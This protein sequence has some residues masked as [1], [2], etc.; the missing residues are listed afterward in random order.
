MLYRI[1]KPGLSATV[2]VRPQINRIAVVS[3]DIL[4]IEREADRGIRISNPAGIVSSACTSIL[5]R[6]KVLT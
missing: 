2:V 5:L 6:N 1:E 3:A 4:Q